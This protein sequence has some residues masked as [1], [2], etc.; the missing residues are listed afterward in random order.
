VLDIWATAGVASKAMAASDP[1]RVFMT[2]SPL[3]R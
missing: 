1:M 3:P 2:L